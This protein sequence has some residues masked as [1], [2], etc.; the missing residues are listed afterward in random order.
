MNNLII[1]T[2]SE[3]TVLKE[4][5]SMLVKSGLL[6]SSIKTPEQAMVIMLKGKELGIPPMQ[7][8]S[9]I[10]VVQGKP[11]IG[12]ELM[13]G[14][15]YKAYPTAVIDYEVSSNTACVINATR[16][17]GKPSKF[18]F[19]MDDAKKANLLGKSSWTQY[20]AAMLRARCISAMA[21]A[22]FPDA[23]MGASYTAEELGAEVTEEGEVINIPAVLDKQFG[24]VAQ[25][26][27]T[28]PT[29]PIL[30]NEEAEHRRQA[31]KAECFKS[32]VSLEKIG[33]ILKTEFN[34][35]KVH[36]LTEDETGKL[37]DIIR[38]INTGAQ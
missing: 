11:T 33:P 23:L 7:A 10:S 17:G 12:A 9:S 6:P 30:T 27:P 26:L 16:P 2:P 25:G 20:P 38:T 37:L 3:L 32:D 28:N 24:V 18:S 31:V 8:F 29:A 21:R 1:P 19:N 14:L 4:L 35:E 15:I 34:K 22:V 5:G 36:E 13:L